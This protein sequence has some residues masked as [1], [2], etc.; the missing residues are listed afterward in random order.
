MNPAMREAADCDYHKWKVKFI[1]RPARFKSN[2][3]EIHEVIADGNKTGN[4]FEISSLHR[5]PKRKHDRHRDVESSR[6]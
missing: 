1:P 5:T 3:D 6:K 4:M 2:N